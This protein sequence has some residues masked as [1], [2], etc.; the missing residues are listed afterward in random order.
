[1][2]GRRPSA[3]PVPAFQ[4]APR[5]R[6]DIG[7]K[8]LWRLTFCRSGEAAKRCPVCIAIL[9]PP[10]RCLSVPDHTP[11]TVRQRHQP[12]VPLG[13]LL[14]QRGREALSHLQRDRRTSACR[15]GASCTPQWRS[16]RCGGGRVPFFAGTHGS[17]GQV[18]AS[19]HDC[20]GTNRHARP[21]PSGRA[22]AAASAIMRRL[23]AMLDDAET[24]G[25]SCNAVNYILRL[26]FRFIKSKVRSARQSRPP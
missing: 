23:G 18:S 6:R 2:T 10:R 9:A 7:I 17:S 16:P 8:P 25:D 22:V 24:I 20:A 11:E 3:P 1:M 21:P 15:R 12:A 4:P 19:R 26:I 14:S 13:H 5:E